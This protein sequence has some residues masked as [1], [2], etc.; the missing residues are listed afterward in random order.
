MFQM[1]CSSP[2]MM[3]VLLVV[4]SALEKVDLEG[5]GV[6]F[7]AKCLLNRLC[8]VVEIVV[9][10]KRCALICGL[11]GVFV[12]LGTSLLLSLLNVPITTGL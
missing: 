4:I 12:A 3:Y 8:K 7:F 5:V 11:S 6:L 1:R 9:T 10:E 2:S